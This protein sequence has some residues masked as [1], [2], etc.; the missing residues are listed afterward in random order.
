[1]DYAVKLAL[2]R[3]DYFSACIYGTCTATVPASRLACPFTPER[4]LGNR[5]TAEAGLDEDLVGVLRGDQLDQHAGQRRADAAGVREREV[6]ARHGGGGLGGAPRAGDRDVA[7]GRVPHGEGLQAAAERG[8]E[9]G[10]RV[11]QQPQ[12]GEEAGRELR[13]TLKRRDELRVPGGDVEVDGRRHVGE[14]RD[15]LG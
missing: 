10:G 7:V 6:R 4:R 1:R 11:E 14:V 3:T 8:R 2:T 15:G 12:P 13:V 5:P 9:R